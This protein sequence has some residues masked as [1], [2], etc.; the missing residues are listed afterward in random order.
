MGLTGAVKRNVRSGFS[1]LSN[2]YDSY[3]EVALTEMIFSCRTFMQTNFKS[4]SIFFL[5]Y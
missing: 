3:L 2:C 4:L 1:F 5:F